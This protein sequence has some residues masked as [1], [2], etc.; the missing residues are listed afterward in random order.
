MMQSLQITPLSPVGALVSGVDLRDELEEGT[1]RALREAWD[2]HALL[3]FREQELTADDLKRL[4]SVFGTVSDQGEAPGGMN[5]VS[6]VYKPGLNEK[7]EHTL[8]GGD[9]ELHMHFDHCFQEH[10]LRGILL[11]SVEVPPEGGD[12]IFSDVRIATRRLPPDIRARIDGKLIRHKSYLRTGQPEW[13][14]PIMYE[15]PRTAERILFFSKLQARE[16]LGIPEGEC[17]TLFERFTSII[18]DDDIIYRHHWQ[19]KDVV[20]WDN[21]ALQHARETFDPKYHR[22]LQR[23]QIGG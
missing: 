21:I 7:G 18:E 16:I 14:H 3:L 23:V 8:R 5:L 2:D 1:R 20:V 15:H 19:P 4:A 11:Y 9:G 10:P 17:K 6:N 12:T 13:N 22:H